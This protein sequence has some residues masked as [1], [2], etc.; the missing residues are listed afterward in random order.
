MRGKGRTEE[1]TKEKR[2]IE[3]RNERWKGH[4]INT[5]EIRNAYGTLVE[6]MK[7]KVFE[8][9]SVKV[10]TGFNWLRTH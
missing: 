2:A 9:Q 5:W 10:R 7:R 1:R 4:V 8:K 6:N 3:S